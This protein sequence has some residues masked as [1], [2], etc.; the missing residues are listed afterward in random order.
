LVDSQ[1]LVDGLLIDSSI[2]IN[3]EASIDRFP[4]LD[5][6][7]AI[8]GIESRTLN[9]THGMHGWIPMLASA[10]GLIASR[11]SAQQIVSE[12]MVWKPQITLDHP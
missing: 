3:L 9:G 8:P 12:S 10:V 1:L 4:D 2:S 5:R 6:G 7:I 11:N